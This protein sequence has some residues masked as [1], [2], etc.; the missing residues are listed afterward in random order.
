MNLC[1]N[2]C[3]TAPPLL[4]VSTISQREVLFIFNRGCVFT[5][6]A[7]VCAAPFKK[8]KGYRDTVNDYLN[9]VQSPSAYCSFRT[10]RQ[11]DSQIISGLNQSL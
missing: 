10:G 11:T 4:R 1:P 8:K 5:L 7:T 9:S 3:C 2:F 6:C